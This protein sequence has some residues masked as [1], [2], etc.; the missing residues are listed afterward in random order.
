MCSSDLL[1]SATSYKSLR[2]DAMETERWN[3]LHPAEPPRQ[4]ILDRTLNTGSGPVVAVTDFMR[5]VSEQV[6]PHVRG[7]RF[8]ALGTDGMG[9]SDT[10]AALR[11][12]FETDAEHVTVA[13]LSALVG[14]HGITAGTVRDAIRDLGID[15]DAPNGLTRD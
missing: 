14:S 4:S 2:D 11:R 5:I 12:F 7:R 9:R 15:P 10:R 3:R 8:L 13:V 1:W 6:A